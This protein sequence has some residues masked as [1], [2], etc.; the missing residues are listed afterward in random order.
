MFAVLRLAEVILS[1]TEGE[2]ERLTN[3]NQEP[4]EELL[5]YREWFT[6]YLNFN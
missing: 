2:I 1:Q 5:I 6:D 3:L 4:S